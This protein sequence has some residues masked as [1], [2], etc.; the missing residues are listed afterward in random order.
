[1]VAFQKEK[2][3]LA[4]KPKYPESTDIS[5]VSHDKRNARYVGVITGFRTAKK[6]L[7]IKTSQ[8]RR[9]L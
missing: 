8:K 3:H 2:R 5:Q 7:L 9:Q 1:M 4:Q 6:A